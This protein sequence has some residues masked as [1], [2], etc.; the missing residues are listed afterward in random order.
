MLKDYEDRYCL[1]LDILG[2]KDIVNNSVKDPQKE[3][4]PQTSSVYFGLKK[5]TENLDYKSVLIDSAGNKVKSSRRVAQFSDTVVVSYL[6]RESGGLSNILYDV[7]Q[8]QLSLIR[9]KLLVRGAITK[10]KLYHRGDFVFGPALNDAAELEKLAMYPRVIADKELLIAAGVVKPGLGK[11][12]RG[13]SRSP[14][15]LVSMDLDGLFYVDYFA[16][17]EEDFHD[18]W[19]D[20]IE[21]LS[22]LRE[23]IVG[24]SHKHPLSVKMKHSWMRQKFNDIAFP[25]EASKYT[26]FCDQYVPDD[27]QDFIANVQ[28]FK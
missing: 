10:G 6:V 24:L 25:L 18:D 15:S 7:L 3:S 27:E 5:I 9:R 28:P 23:V 26:K 8:V 2:F 12:D 20:L 17:F 22:D 16:V 1:F 4:R 21:Y 14:Q 19:G 13:T 11:H